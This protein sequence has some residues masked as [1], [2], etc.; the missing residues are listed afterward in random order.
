MINPGTIYE[1]PDKGI[2]VREICEL[3]PDN[4]EVHSLAYALAEQ[5]ND[6]GIRQLYTVVVKQGGRPW[7]GRS[8]EIAGWRAPNFC[9]FPQS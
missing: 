5:P 4:V 1:A 2:M 6:Y 3:W 7:D 9:G 8:A